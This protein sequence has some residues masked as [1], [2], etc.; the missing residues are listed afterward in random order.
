MTFS[1]LRKKTDE[2]FKTSPAL[3]E[4]DRQRIAKEVEAYL[5]A[6]GRIDEV[7]IGRSGE[8]GG[9]SRIV[10]THKNKSDEEV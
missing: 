5:K 3:R 8:K 1:T 2:S 7:A 9:Y 4:A 6:G 10:I